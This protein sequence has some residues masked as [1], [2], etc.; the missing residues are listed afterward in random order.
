MSINDKEVNKNFGK[1]LEDSRGLIAR[2]SKNILK[3][4]KRF[5]E[6]K[7]HE[8]YQVVDLIVKKAKRTKSESLKVLIAR[9]PQTESGKEI[10]H[11][12]LVFYLSSEKLIQEMEFH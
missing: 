4:V 3:A 7:S 10:E 9:I 2:I 12:I 6:V 11:L 1:V 5:N 8:Y